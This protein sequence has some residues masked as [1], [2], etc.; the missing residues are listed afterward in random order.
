MSKQLRVLWSPDY[1]QRLWCVF[2][3]AAYRKAN[4]AGKIVLAPLYI[5]AIVSS[6]MLGSYAVVVM[7]WLTQAMSVRLSFTYAGYILS[8]IP[9]YIA[10]HFL[11]LCTRQ[12]MQLVAELK[13]FDVELAECRSPYDREFVFEGITTWYGSKT[14]FNDYV[15]GPL[16]LELIE[17]L[18]RN[19]VPAMY[20]CLLVTPT[21]TSGFE[22]FMA[23]WKGGGTREAL[24]SHFIGVVIGAQLCWFLVSLK[25]GFA[26]C[27]RFASR[28]R[29]DLVKTLLIFLVFVSCVVFGTAL[30]TIAYTSSLNAAIAFTSGAMLI[31]VFSFEWRRIW[32][33]RHG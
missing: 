9:A 33:L 25:L 21:L 8:L 4:P 1:L 7:F 13:S 16:F 18:S 19:Q 11:R 23:I 3:L 6:T 12:K 17:P 24:L 29:L 5:E 14:A 28:S 30:A 27:Y 20:W 32:R 31:A 26:L 10:F 2:E 22:F 15:R